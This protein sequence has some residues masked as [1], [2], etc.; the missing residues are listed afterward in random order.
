MGGRLVPGPTDGRGWPSPPPPPRS[1]A[2]ARNVTREQAIFRTVRLTDFW[3]LAAIQ[4]V[5]RRGGG[6]LCEYLFSFSFSR[7]SEKQENL[8]FGPIRRERPLLL[9]GQW[10]K[11]LFSGRKKKEEG[12]GGRFKAG[13]WHFSYREGGRA[14]RSVDK[15]LEALTR[16]EKRTEVNELTTDGDETD[17]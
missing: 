12:G 6:F 15:R 16:G 10:I 1:G 11:L 7:E 8:L 3:G 13:L 9:L 17:R 14:D 5:Q 2:A 4:I